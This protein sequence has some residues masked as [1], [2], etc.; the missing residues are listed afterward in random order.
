MPNFV[1]LDNV[2]HA[3]L[4]VK[5][6]YSEATQDTI[7]QALVFPTEFQMLQREY[8]IFFRQD[9]E[10]KFFAVVI[11]G[12]DKDEN[13][14]LDEGQWQARYIPAMQERG[15]FILEDAGDDPIVRINVDD[16][17]VSSSTGEKIFLTHGGYTPY[18]EEVLKTLQRV[19]IGARV[20]DD[21]F[22]YL[23]SFDLLEPINIQVSLNDDQRYVIPELFTISHSKMADLTGQQL[24]DLNQLGLLEHCFAILSSTGNVSRLID[25]KVLKGA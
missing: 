24:Y 14:F 4:R 8:P 7:N 22:A 5:V 18:F 25:M 16:A 9:N 20:V 21:F 17:R 12:L 10:G 2:E 3:S 1:P 13:L 11:L 19:H 23:Q 15:P 6:R